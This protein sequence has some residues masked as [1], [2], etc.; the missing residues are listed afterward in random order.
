MYKFKKTVLNH[1]EVIMVK[2]YNSLT[3][4]MNS[5]L[6]SFWID[7]ARYHGGDLE[8]ISIP[9]LFQNPNKIFHALQIKTMTIITDDTL[10]TN[11]DDQVNCYIEICTLFYHVEKF[12]IKN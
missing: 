7:R 9:T 4:L 12:I 11:L 2:K 10:L 1:T 6:D 3:S 8:G 5:T